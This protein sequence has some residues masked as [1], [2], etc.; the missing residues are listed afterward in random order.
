MNEDEIPL[1]IPELVG[2][3]QWLDEKF[4]P[5]EVLELREASIEYLIDRVREF[6][7]GQ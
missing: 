2:F 6:R 4:G 1:T 3:I 7:S 5:E